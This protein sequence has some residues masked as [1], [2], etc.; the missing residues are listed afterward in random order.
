V[1]GD[2][3]SDVLVTL[4]YPSTFD[5]IINECT[6]ADIQVYFDD[7]QATCVGT[8]NK[9]IEDMTNF[10]GKMK[11]RIV[12]ELEATLALDKAT[13]TSDNFS[14]CCA[15]RDELGE[16]AGP[17]VDLAAFLGVDQLNGQS[18]ATLAKGSKLKRRIKAVDEQR[19][20]LGRLSK[21][22][23]GGAMR[24]FFSGLLPAATYG[25][26]VLGLSD[27]ELES[28][29]RIAMHAMT[30][31]G[32][33]RSRTA[34]LVARGDPAWRPSV[35]PVIRWAQE[36]WWTACPRKSA[37][38]ALTPKDLNHHWTVA[39]QRWPKRWAQ[40][41]GATDA[42]HL[43]LVRIGWKFNDAFNLITDQ[44]VKVPLLET[45]PKLLTKMLQAAVQRTWQKAMAAKLAKEGFDAERVCPDP[46]RVLLAS[47]W[48]KRNPLE[49]LVALRGLLWWHLDRGTGCR[50]WL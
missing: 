3:L 2:S 23:K 37:A 11:E 13:V 14:L 9:I 38:R 31:Q 17:P 15:L 39:S 22:V 4:Y 26:E 35:G 36:V 29:R 6:V 8:P 47:A 33:A 19:Q 24:V 21:G 5:D 50:R 20:R 16:D 48:C 40:S 43:S 10:A 25:V 45:S 32:K 49:G 30:P 1:A 46:I 18:R 7:L 12:N 41:R 34:L 42:A 44:G 27:M 28:I